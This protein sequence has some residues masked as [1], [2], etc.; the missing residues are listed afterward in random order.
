MP[1]IDDEAVG[2]RSG[3]YEA[4]ME[5]IETEL[6]THRANKVTPT[7]IFERWLEQMRAR[8]PVDVPAYLLPKWARPRLEAGRPMQTA[9]VSPDGRVLFRA[10]SAA[11]T[12]ERLGL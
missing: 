8:R 4:V 10:E 6:S 11:E 3:V 12:V 7:P 1:I 9:L 5:A 2:R